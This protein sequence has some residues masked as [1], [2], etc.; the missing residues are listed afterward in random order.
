MFFVA[1]NLVHTIFQ[2]RVC[3]GERGE[4]ECADNAAVRD[5]RRACV[6][7]QNAGVVNGCAKGRRN[8]LPKCKVATF[9]VTCMCIG[10]NFRVKI[11]DCVTTGRARSSPSRCN[12]KRLA[13]CT[14]RELNNVYSSFRWRSSPEAAS[15]WSAGKSF[16]LNSYN[17]NNNNNN[18]LFI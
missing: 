6:D 14:K 15:E 16:D 9:G 12:R 1:Q 8:T 18:I 17:N 4:A 2:Y 11:R 3:M 10:T 5:S 7:V 13:V